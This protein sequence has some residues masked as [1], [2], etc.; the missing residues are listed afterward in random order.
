MGAKGKGVGGGLFGLGQDRELGSRGSGQ[1]IGHWA[2]QAVQGLGRGQTPIYPCRG[3][4]GRTGCIR[5]IDRPLRL[6]RRAFTLLLFQSGN[7]R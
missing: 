3:S 7:W 2:R 4:A 5:D 6:P 1:R